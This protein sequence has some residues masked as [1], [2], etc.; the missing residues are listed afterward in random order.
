LD[1]AGFTLD[2][3]GT[4]F[5]FAKFMTGN[6]LYTTDGKAPT[7]TIDKAMIVVGN[8]I[9]DS[10][11]RD[12]KEYSIKR[13]LQLP[14]PKNKFPET[15]EINAISID[16]LYGYEIIADGKNQ[17]KEKEIIYQVILFESNA[18]YFIFTGTAIDKFDQYLA[19]FKTIARSFKRK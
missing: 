7:K 5:K 1:A 9:E 19:T 15:K 3:S 11:I 2:I 16:S 18:G 4:K 10:I 14:H 13:L 12:R 8:S 6:F 17:N